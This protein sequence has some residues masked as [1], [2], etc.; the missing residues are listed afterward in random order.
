MEEELQHR[1]DTDAL[2][3]QMDVDAPT[4]AWFSGRLAS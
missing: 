4:R 3:W 2:F 1:E